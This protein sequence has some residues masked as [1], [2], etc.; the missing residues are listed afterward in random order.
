VN[1]GL[2]SKFIRANKTALK[3]LGIKA[4]DVPHT[5]GKTF[6]PTRLKRSGG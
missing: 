4:E 2:D 1:E 6:I 5:Y 3:T